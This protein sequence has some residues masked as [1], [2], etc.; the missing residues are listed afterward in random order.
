MDFDPVE[1]QRA[2]DIIRTQLAHIPDLIAQLH[3]AAVTAAR[4]PGV[5]G[6]VAAGMLG[7]A[8]PIDPTAAAVLTPLGDAPPGGAAPVM[9]FDY[10]WRWMDQRG[11]ASTVQGVLR[12][13]QLPV[14]SH[15]KG[16][17]ADRYATAVTSQSSAAGRVATASGAAAGTLLICAGSGIAFYIALSVIVFRLVRGLMIAIA[18][19]ASEAFSWAGVLIAVEESGLAVGLIVAAIAALGAVLASQATTMTTLHGELVDNSQF[20]K[21]HWPRAVADSYSDATV[22]DGDAKWSVVS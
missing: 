6:S 16:V 17:A 2:I 14:R 11:A 8:A 13:D 1:Y 7:L 21:G 9:M 20:H 15:W 18:A 12:P 4:Q 3:D 10:A 22:T 5:V 19:F